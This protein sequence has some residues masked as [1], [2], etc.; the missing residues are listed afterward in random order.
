MQIDE[1]STSKGGGVGEL[2]IHSGLGGFILV[3]G[4]TRA[5]GEEI[6][7]FA[8]FDQAPL[9]LGMEALAQLAALHLRWRIDFARHAFLMTIRD[10]RTEATAPPCGSFGFKGGL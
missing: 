9:T 7:G 6:A 4:I 10:C 2:H 8:V 5:A 3:K 1:G